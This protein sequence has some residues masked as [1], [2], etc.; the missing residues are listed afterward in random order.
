MKLRIRLIAGPRKGAYWASPG[1][2]TVQGQEDAFV[3]DLDD[4]VHRKF[5]LTTEPNKAFVRY[6]LVHEPVLPTVK[7]LLGC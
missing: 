7:E 2:G 4:V 5:L 6:E 3:Y 1:K